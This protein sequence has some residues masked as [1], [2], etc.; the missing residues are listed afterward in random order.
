LVTFFAWGAGKVAC[1]HH[2]PYNQGFLV[3]PVEQ[4]IATP[5]D[6]ALEFHHRLATLDFAGAREIA[7]P[8]ALELVDASEKSCDAPC[9]RERSVRQLHVLTRAVTLEQTEETAKVRAEAHFRGDVQSATY[10]LSKEGKLWKV[11]K[12]VE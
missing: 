4:L 1:N 12:R 10:E 8:S 2:P 11:G 3:A 7:M 9:A 5:K 6:A